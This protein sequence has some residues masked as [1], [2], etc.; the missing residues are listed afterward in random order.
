[1]DVGAVTMSTIDGWT[2]KTSATRRARAIIHKNAAAP[3]IAV[4]TS[5][6]CPRHSL[7]AVMAPKPLTCQARPV[8]TTTPRCLRTCAWTDAGDE[9]NCMPR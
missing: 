4:S 2:T 7:L 5:R 6:V 3:C 8:M 1:M 9:Q